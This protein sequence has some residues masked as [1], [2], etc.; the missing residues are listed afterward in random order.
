MEWSI[1][2]EV[3]ILRVV[4]RSPSEQSPP[5]CCRPLGR[6]RRR[7]WD[8][9]RGGRGVVRRRTGEITEG[10]RSDGLGWSGMTGRGR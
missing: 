3:T 10:K 6:F 5:A 9:R 4:R 2:M 8:R 1:G 7:C